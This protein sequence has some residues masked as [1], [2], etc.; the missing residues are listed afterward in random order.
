MVK[1]LLGMP[2]ICSEVSVLSSSP[3]LIQHSSGR[4]QAMAQVVEA[5]QLTGS[6]CCLVMP[7]PS[8]EN[9]ARGTPV[10][11]THTAVVQPHSPVSCAGTARDMSWFCTQ[12]QKEAALSSDYPR[13]EDFVVI[14]SLSSWQPHSCPLVPGLPDLGSQATE[15]LT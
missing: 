6:S 7:W 14:A 1:S 4:Q 13:Q 8:T 15:A 9:Q 10:P 2:T 12:D 3:L 11:E 5:L